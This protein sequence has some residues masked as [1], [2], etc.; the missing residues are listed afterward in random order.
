MPASRAAEA[1]LQFLMEGVLFVPAAVL[2]QLDLA[3]DR[4]LVT[5][6]LVI[7]VLADGALEFDQVIL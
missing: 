4:F 7:D 3:F 2:H 1:L 6:R 5:R